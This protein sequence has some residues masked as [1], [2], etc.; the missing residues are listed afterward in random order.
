MLHVSF[1]VIFMLNGSSS[2]VMRIRVME[3]AAPRGWP[4]SVFPLSLNCKQFLCAS[5]Y[6]AL[7][8]L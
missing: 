4:G 2:L 5:L 3:C 6:G 7:P 1:S 8:W